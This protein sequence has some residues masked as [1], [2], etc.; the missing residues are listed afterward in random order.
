[1]ED[2][3]Q[4]NV[5]VGSERRKGKKRVVIQNGMDQHRVAGESKMRERADGEHQIA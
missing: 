3:G 5:Y 4:M 2:E 1:V